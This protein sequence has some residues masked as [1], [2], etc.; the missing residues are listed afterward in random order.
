MTDL[1]LRSATDGGGTG[2]AC[3]GGAAVGVIF[4]GVGPG[5]LGSLG[6]LNLAMG[7]SPGA[8]SA[9]VGRAVTVGALSVPQ[10]WSPGR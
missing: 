4:S 2:P 10:A 9:G 1:L 3:G 8:V 6:A 5:P 7:G